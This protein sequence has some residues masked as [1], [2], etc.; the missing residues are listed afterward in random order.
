VVLIL[1]SLG[2]VGVVAAT[3][4]FDDVTGYRDGS[5]ERNYD[6]AQTLVR[7]RERKPLLDGHLTIGQALRFG[8]FMVLWAVVLLTATLAVAPHRPGWAIG[9][10][11]LV[12][13]M[14]VQ[15][16][17]GLRL[18]YRGGQELV[19]FL[20]TALTVVI[21][22]GLLTGKVTGLVLVEGYLFGLWSLLVPMYSNINDEPG[23]RAAG[24]RNLM[25]LCPPGLYRVIVGLLSATEVLAVAVGIATTKG[26]A[27]WFLLLLAPVIAI[28]IG[29]VRIGL[30]RRNP[31]V[32]RKLGIKAHRLGVVLVLVA[33]LLITR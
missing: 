13:V 26:R 23:D 30:L 22:Y 7:S 8:W 1:V 3:V 5:D 20:S 17:Y 29:Q 19:M 24:R 28:R 9:L 14:S 2:W 33:N 15:Y 16:S 10:T 27:A 25:T 32:A 21:P 11:V 4:T 6:P 18:S 12:V 31:L